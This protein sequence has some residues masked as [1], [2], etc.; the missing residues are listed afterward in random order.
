MLACGGIIPLCGAKLSEPVNQ[1]PKCS[2]SDPNDPDFIAKSSPQKSDLYLL[3]QGRQTTGSAGQAV[4]STKP[5]AETLKIQRKKIEGLNTQLENLLKGDGAQAVEFNQL[6]NKLR[7][8]F[9]GVESRSTLISDLTSVEQVCSRIEAELPTRKQSLS[10]EAYSLVQNLLGKYRTEIELLR[11]LVS[12]YFSR[13]TLVEEAADQWI[14]VY[15]ELKKLTGK[16]SAQKEVESEIVRFL[17]SN[18]LAAPQGTGWRHP[19]D[20]K[21][22]KARLGLIVMLNPAGRPS[23]ISSGVKVET[24]LKGS[25][26]EKAGLQAGD[27]ISSLNG[28][29]VLNKGDFGQ[30]CAS[31]KGGD[32]VKVQ[33]RRGTEEKNLLFNAGDGNGIVE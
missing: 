4:S 26:S 31:L 21:K 30:F 11:S 10:P 25:P 2:S 13:I 20:Y 7:A 5:V 14:L 9:P 32:S 28:Q 16:E 22:V 8:I 27:V 23:D 33:F 15:E 17:K 1:G 24:I 6:I 3:I 18:F 29:S 12:G 19:D